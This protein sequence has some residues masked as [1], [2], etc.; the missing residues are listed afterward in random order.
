VTAFDFEPVILAPEGVTTPAPSPAFPGDLDW[1]VRAGRAARSEVRRP[2]RLVRGV[3]ARDLDVGPPSVAVVDDRNL[4]DAAVLS[5]VEARSATLA[6]QR[7]RA[8][9]LVVEAHEIGV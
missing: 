4:A 1:H 7:A 3:P 5:S 2:D 6:R 9:Q 8:G